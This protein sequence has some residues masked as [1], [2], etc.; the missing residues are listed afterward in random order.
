VPT[1][2]TEAQSDWPAAQLEELQRDATGVFALRAGPYPPEY[3]SFE[4]GSK[5]VGMIRRSDGGTWLRTAS[6]EWRMRV[7]RRRRLGWQLAF[8]PTGEP[9]ALV[10]YSPRTLRQGGTLEILGGARFALRSPILRTDWRVT[11]A[12]RH[13]VALIAFRMHARPVLPN[14]Q[15]HPLS[16]RAADE[17][18][19]PVV[20]LAAGAAILVHNEE[21]RPLTGGSI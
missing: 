18:L 4:Q 7:V 19:L 20:M 5:P 2:I 13:E 17:P 14:L 9:D 8:A 15:K 6:E 1:E 10:R 16:R 12:P 21:L 3:W 11:A